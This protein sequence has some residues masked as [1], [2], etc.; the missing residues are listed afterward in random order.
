MNEIHTALLLEIKN[1]DRLVIESTNKLATIDDAISTQESLSNDLAPNQDTCTPLQNT[2]KQ[3]LAENALGG[4]NDIKALELAISKSQLADDKANKQR[5]DDK[6]SAAATIAGLVALQELEQN[7][8]SGLIHDARR[9]RLELLNLIATEHA[10]DYE[11]NALK[12]VEAL[13]N[14]L[15]V[16]SLIGQV[17]GDYRLTSNL[18]PWGN[19]EVTLPAINEGAFLPMLNR[20]VNTMLIDSERFTIKDR[21]NSERISA[22]VVLIG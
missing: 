2:Y 18:L 10:T 8:Q 22:L 4:S 1:I 15:A 12:T 17:S 14:L 13:R 20:G 7:N 5:I 9:K 19:F 3:A 21:G 6:A 11:A 16:D